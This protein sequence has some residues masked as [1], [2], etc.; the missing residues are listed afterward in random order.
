VF[1]IYYI[2]HAL[3]IINSRVHVARCFRM[4]KRRYVSPRAFFFFFYSICSLVSLP[5]ALRGVFKSYILLS[6][7]VIFIVVVLVVIVP[8]GFVELALFLPCRKTP[9]AG[10]PGSLLYYGLVFTALQRPKMFRISPRTFFFFYSICSL[11]SNISGSSRRFWIL[12]FA[13]QVCY[14][15]VVVLDDFFMELVLFLLCR[16]TPAAGFPGR[17][18]YYGLVFGTALQHPRMFGIS[19]RT[20]KTNDVWSGEFFISRT[21][22]RFVPRENTNR[23]WN[24]IKAPSIIGH[25]WLSE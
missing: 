22:R 15:I 4:L 1:H 21:N 10:F 3:L 18:L 16:K 8:D 19:P 5:V 7:F 20:L 13:L 11:V 9:A 14:F 12:C 24:R 17:L 25:K 6:G 2:R 23:P